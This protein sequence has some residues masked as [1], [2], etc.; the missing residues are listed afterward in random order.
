MDDFPHNSVLKTAHHVSG[1]SLRT[2][3]LFRIH[4]KSKQ[5]MDVS[6]NLL[7]NLLSILAKNIYRWK[8]FQFNRLP[9]IIFKIDSI[10]ILTLESYKIKGKK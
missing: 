8:I 10:H 7:D 4:I 3:Q 9:Q 1:L 6:E 2:L 5:N